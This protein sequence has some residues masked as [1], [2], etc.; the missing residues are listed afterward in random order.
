MGAGERDGF[1]GGRGY[2]RVR[3]GT[4]LMGGAAGAPAWADSGGRGHRLRDLGALPLLGRITGLENVRF[5]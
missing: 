1:G 3:A 5:E 2:L 4:F